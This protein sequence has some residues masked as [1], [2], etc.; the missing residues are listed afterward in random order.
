M[1]KNSEIICYY[2][3][4]SGD[5]ALFNKKGMPVKNSS[6]SFML[7]LLKVKANNDIARKFEE[8]KSK[9]LS[10]P[11]FQS[12]ASFEK[13]RLQFHAKDDHIAIKREMFYF[14]AELDFS[15]QVVVRRKATLIEQAKMQFK[16]TGKKFTDRELYS[17]LVGRLFK[18]NIHKAEEYKI[19]FSNRGKTFTNH[20]LENALLETK[21]KFI[22]DRNLSSNSRFSVFC[23]QPSMHP[24]LQIIDYCL[25][26][27]QRLYEKQEDVYFN[28]IKDKFKLILDVDDK[29][30]SP[31]GAHYHKRNILTLENI[32]GTS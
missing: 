15:V 7:G 28:I 23:S 3:D 29:R 1:I 18:Q 14:I 25:W 12:F 6:I 4:E 16:Y 9:I 5:F 8:F 17:D 10:D 20:T 2:V 26:A 30:K 32:N 11:I 13:T 31:A 21:E 22:I 27:L 24:E 19:Y